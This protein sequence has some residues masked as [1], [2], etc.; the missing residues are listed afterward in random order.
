MADYAKDVLVDTQW[1]ENHL[2]DDSI[3]VVEVDENPGLYAEAHIP[4]SHRLRLE[5][6]P[7]GPGQARLPRPG[8]VRRALRTPRHLERPHH[9]PLRRPQQLVRRL[10]LLVPQVLRPRQRE[11]DER[12][13]REVDLRGAADVEGRAELR[14]TAVQRPEGRPRDPRHARRGQRRARHRHAPRGRPLA[15]GVLGRADRHGWL[16]AGGRSARGPH[17]RRRLGAVG[18]GRAGG[19]DLQVGRRAEASSTAARA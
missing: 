19:R 11:A 1:V 18:A 5:E 7:S 8:R 13:A 4:G 14:P 12:T 6:G 10:H 16:R 3:R 17:P 15:A 9:R 2:N